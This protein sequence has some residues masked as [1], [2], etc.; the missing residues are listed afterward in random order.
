MGDDDLRGAVH[1]GLCV[2]ALDVAVLGQQHAALRVGEVALRLAIGL[3]A[4]RLG[5]LA[6]LLAALRDAFLLGLRLAPR[7]L[8][9][10]CLR[11]SLQLGLRG[12]DLGQP[13]LLV[14]NPA[15]QLVAAPGPVQLVLLSVGGLAAANRS[16]PLYANL[17]GQFA[18]AVRLSSIGR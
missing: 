17:D 12:A 8:L 7:L 3:R 6:V 2:P 18:P 10:G 1:G 11:F 5:G 16:S 14:G 15:G 4:R 13:L 9:G